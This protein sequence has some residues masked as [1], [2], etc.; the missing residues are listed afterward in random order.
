MGLVNRN[1]GKHGMLGRGFQLG[2]L[3]L[4]LVGSYLGYQAQN[5]LLGEGEERKA[6][7]RQQ[8]SRRVRDELGVLKGAVMKLGQLLSMQNK[9]LPEEALRELSDL[10]MRAPG[11]HATLARAQFKAALGKYPE[12]VFREFDAEPFA[13]ASLGQVHRAITRSGERVA[14]KIQYPAIR[15]AIENDFKLL[16]SAT[17]PGRL[18]GHFPAALV[19][20]FQRSFLEETDYVRE[21]D[22]L[23]FFREGL[24]SLT[25][26]TIP[27]VYRELST[28]RVLTMSH[29]EGEIL[30]D[31]LKR[32]PPSAV[33]DL[34]GARLGEMHDTQL[35][36]LKVVHADH[37]PGNYLLRPDGR[38][39]LVDFGCVKRF[40]FDIAELMHCYLERTW[41]KSEAAE[42]HFLK[43]IFNT[44]VPYK[45]VRKVLP[46]LERLCDMI[47]PQDDSANAVVDF[48]DPKLH[49]LGSQYGRLILR[50]K[51]IVPEFALVGRAQMG[52]HHILYE[53]GARVNVKEVWHRV[54]T[55]GGIGERHQTR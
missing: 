3:G 17:L 1:N 45:R 39:G 37:H 2:K 15:S 28:D 34:I 16:R 51:L 27:R 41:R 12:E 9:V 21:A 36:W 29:V 54:L 38:I 42:R 43:L 40:D 48:R 46:M 14:V 6:R 20:E 32:K 53:L 11:M 24:S 47:Y 4:S 13:A 26:L 55:A 52:L 8:A 35:H 7:F 49:E 31:F 44:K 5:L 18:S 19:D 50:E 33:R 22:N 25:Y 23:E 30:R 10:Q